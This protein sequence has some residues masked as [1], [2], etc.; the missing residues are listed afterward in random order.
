MDTAA[1]AVRRGQ[2][3]AARHVVMVTPM[4]LRLV[5]ADNVV[6]IASALDVRIASKATLAD[7]KR[8]VFVHSQRTERISALRQ[9]RAQR[10]E[11]ELERRATM[12]SEERQRYETALQGGCARGGMAAETPT[13]DCPQA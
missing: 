4:A 3:K 13:Y 8:V 1:L 10:E 12:K 9:Q 11:Q 2:Y 6:W 7:P 5:T